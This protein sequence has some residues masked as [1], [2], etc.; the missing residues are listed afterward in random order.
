MMLLAV[1]MYVLYEVGIVLVKIVEKRKKE[2]NT[3]MS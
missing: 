3:A 2:D 1:P